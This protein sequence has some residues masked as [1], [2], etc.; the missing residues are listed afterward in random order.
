MKSKHNRAKSRLAVIVSSDVEIEIILGCLE[1]LGDIFPNHIFLLTGNLDRENFSVIKNKMK[2]LGD[3]LDY[4]DYN[5][6][7]SSLIKLFIS[8]LIFGLKKIEMAVL[9]IDPYSIRLNTKDKL[10]ASFVSLGKI[11][12]YDTDKNGP[13]FYP[14]LTFLFKTIKDVFLIY[15]QIFKPAIKLILFIPGLLL[16]PVKSIKMLFRIIYSIPD[17]TLFCLTLFCLLILKLKLKLI[18]K[19]SI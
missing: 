11:G 6:K 16:S 10:F 7:T 3:I 1:Y 9:I 19:F 13:T 4:F 15:V 2:A 14:R 18:K 8:A 5:S 17:Y 12:I